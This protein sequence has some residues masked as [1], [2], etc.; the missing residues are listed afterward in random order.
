MRDQ[1][2]FIPYKAHPRRRGHEELPAMR[3][4]RVIA[5]LV[6][7]REQGREA[8]RA[9]LIRFRSEPNVAAAYYVRN[10]D[11]PETAAEWVDR[12]VDLDDLEA[13]IPGERRASSAVCR[14]TRHI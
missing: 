2:N 6:K 3:C 14:D 5:D 9:C 12:W 1:T 8:L 10:G 13:V 7:A 11:T 4:A